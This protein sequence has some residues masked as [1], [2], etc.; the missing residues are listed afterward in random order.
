MIKSG[1]KLK[2]WNKSKKNRSKNIGYRF[3][4]KWIPRI[5]SESKVNFVVSFQVLRNS[6]SKTSWISFSRSTYTREM[7]HSSN[8]YITM[9]ASFPG[10]RMPIIYDLNCILSEIH[11]LPMKLNAA[12]KINCISRFIFLIPWNIALCNCK[13][14][15]K[16]VLNFDFIY[17]YYIQIYLI[18]FYTSRYWI[19]CIKL[20]LSSILF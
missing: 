12:P 1:K 19:Y 6:N 9:I 17:F 14:S 10:Q 13:F 20:L 11:W 4:V 3:Y 2:I 5:R 7:F 16:Q 15:I 18:I 8:A